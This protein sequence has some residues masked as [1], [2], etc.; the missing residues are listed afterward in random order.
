MGPWQFQM[1]SNFL[2]GLPGGLFWV[3]IWV[4]FPQQAALHIANEPLVA[5]GARNAI[6]N[7]VLQMLVPYIYP[8]SVTVGAVGCAYFSLRRSDFSHETLKRSLHKYLYVFGAFGLPI[9]I[10]VGV[11]LQITAVY[12]LFSASIGAAY[13]E[14]AIFILAIGLFSLA[15]WDVRRNARFVFQANG[16]SAKGIRGAPWIRFSLAYFLITC[17]VAAGLLFTFYD[18]VEFILQ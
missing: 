8:L 6:A 12:G 3:L 15:V 18:V 1:F 11:F 16:Y 4:L 14:Q 17:A 5:D 9:Q 2:A 10:A 13:I 7:N